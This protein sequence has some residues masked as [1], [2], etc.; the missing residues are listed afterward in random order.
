MPE[1]FALCGPTRPDAW[2][3]T[4]LGINYMPAGYDHVPENPKQVKKRAKKLKQALAWM[5]E[6]NVPQY[7]QNEFTAYFHDLPHRLPE[8]LDGAFLSLRETRWTPC[9]GRYPS[10]ARI[11]PA[12]IRIT[13]EATP[14][15]A[16]LNGV[17]TC[18][19]MDRNNNGA[20]TI[21][22][23]ALAK[24]D[25]NK[26]ELNWLRRVDD[27]AKW[28]IGNYAAH[29]VAKLDPRIKEIGDGPLC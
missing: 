12:D 21:C 11:Q 27:L 5:T 20:I 17:Y 9:Y 8:W 7:V 29:H 1:Y 6:Q 13:I 26:D 10:L 23:A 14:F 22:V 24:G 16:P 15:W 19:L 28:E 4:P 18:G 3:Q 25:P 2:K